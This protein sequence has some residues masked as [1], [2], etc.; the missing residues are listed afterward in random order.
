M[1][2]FKKITISDKI[3]I[4]EL[5]AASD[6]RGAEYNFTNLFIWEPVYGSKISR[7]KDFLLLTSG[8]GEDTIYLYPAGRGDV[9]EV[10]KVLEKD[11]L[12][13]GV[14]FKLIA[15]PPGE[16]DK[17]EKIFQG[18]VSFEP[19]RNSFDY[20][21]ESEKL[22]SLSGKKLQSKRNHYNRFAELQGWSYED[23]DEKSLEE[24]KEFTKEWCLEIGGCRE[25]KS[26]ES[27]LC[28]VGRALYNF[29]DLSLKG[30]LI[31]YEG[32]VVAYTIGEKLNSDT[33]IVH[34]EKATATLR[35]CYQAI[36]KEFASRYAK[37]LTYINREDDAGDMGLRQAKESYYPVFMQEKFVAHIF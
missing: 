4:D 36:N 6:F 34:I 3:W 31:R 29:K 10:L 13:K 37:D 11:A 12:S 26:L 30:G 9:E 22:I 20:I 2:E 21:Y 24:C 19:A 5:L 8:E 27:E 33:F 28:A 16:R 35:G 7:Y 25:N 1:L 23:I 14:P 15:I 18:R 32:K 17:V